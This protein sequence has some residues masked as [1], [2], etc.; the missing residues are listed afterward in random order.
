M[1]QHYRAG[2]QDIDTELRGRDCSDC[3]TYSGADGYLL[4]RVKVCVRLQGYRI[5][6]NVL[7]RNVD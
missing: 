2:F 4:V 6:T 1:K 3:D 5:C 7:F